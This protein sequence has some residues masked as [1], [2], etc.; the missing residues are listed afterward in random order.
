[1]VYVLDNFE[2]LGVGTQDQYK[3]Y[4]RVKE[5]AP[6]IY[7]V[8]LAYMGRDKSLY[9]TSLRKSADLLNDV[10]KKALRSMDGE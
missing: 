6:T 5:A 2:K 10:I 9:E 4:L 1:M 7:D 3:V 8:F